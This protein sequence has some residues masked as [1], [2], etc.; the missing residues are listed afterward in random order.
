MK[1]RINYIDNGKL[2]ILGM[3]RTVDAAQTVF[4]NFIVKSRDLDSNL[5]TQLK[6]IELTFVICG[7]KKI[8]S[9][10]R[11]Y[12]TKDYVTDVLS[13]PVN[14]SLVKTHR[15]KTRLFAMADLGDIYICKERAKVQAKRFAISEK[16]EIIHLLVHGFLHLVGFDHERSKSDEL[17]M[18]KNEAALV[19]EM[20]KR[21]RGELKK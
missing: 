3:R 7:K 9:L 2:K 13:F 19:D 17:L 11:D 5:I 20:S 4:A 8:R 21:L 15:K 6:D 12:L 16:S 14:D 18:E 1:L 10:N